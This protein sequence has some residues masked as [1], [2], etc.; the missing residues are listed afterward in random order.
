MVPIVSRSAAAFCRSDNGSGVESPICATQA[1]L[2]SKTNTVASCWQR[3]LVVTAFQA[4]WRDRELIRIPLARAN[5][6]RLHQQALISG[7]KLVFQ[8]FE[9][10]VKI[11]L[12]LC[13][14]HSTLFL[15]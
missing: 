10:F 6:I 3:R 4:I 1:V 9:F 12:T 11:D 5:F 13:V 2:A 8:L 7:A 14:V 15:A